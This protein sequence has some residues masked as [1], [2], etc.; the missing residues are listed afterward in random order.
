[1]NLQELRRYLQNK[2]VHPDAVSIGTGLPHETE[3]YCIVKEGATWEVYYSERGAKT[4]L[5]R[6]DSEEKACEYLIELLTR[7][8]SVWLPPHD[9]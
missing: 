6:F 4:S 3:K 5:T 7:D 2:R 9:A 8:E 1:M